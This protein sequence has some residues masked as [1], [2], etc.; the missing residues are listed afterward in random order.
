MEIEWF[1][2][3][4]ITGCFL[5]YFLFRYTLTTPEQRQNE[6]LECLKMTLDLEEKIKIVN[7][8]EKRLDE[9]I[10]R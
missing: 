1:F 4:L 10:R 7:D 5:G 9:I 2:I 6:R 8:L 3:G